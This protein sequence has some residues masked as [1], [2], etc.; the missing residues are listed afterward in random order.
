MTLARYEFTVTDERG[1]IVTDAQVEVR[2]EIAGA[3]LATLYADRDGLTPLG[4]PFNVDPDTAVAAFHVVGGAYRVRPF[5][6]G[7]ERIERYVG[8]GTAAETDANL[9]PTFIATAWVFDDATADADPGS[10]LFRL[11]NATPASATAVY[12]DNENA[13]GNSVT[14]W[15]DALDDG[16]D[17]STRGQLTICDPDQPTEVFR[18]YTVTG[19]VTDGT[20]YRKLS[21]THVSGAGSFTAGTPYSFSFAPLGANVVLTTRTLTAGAGLAGGGDLSANRTFDVG[22]GTGI[23]VN[24][25]DVAVSTDGISNTLLDNMLAW[26]LKARNAGTTGD[27]SDVAV[28]DLTEEADPEPGD[29]LVGFLASG[30]LRKFDVSNVGGGSS[31]SSVALQVFTANDT[32]TPTSGMAFCLVLSTGGG[33]GGGGADV[34]TNATQTGVGSGGG[35]GG[36]AIELFSAATIGANQSVAIGA[37][38]TA[39]SATNGTS[40][41]N[42]GNTTFGSLHTATGGTGGVG[43]GVSSL[44]DV[45][46]LGSAGGVPTG[47][48]LNVTGGSGGS[49]LGFVNTPVGCAM[50]GHGGSSMWGSGGRGGARRGTIATSSAG[51]AGAAYGS[52]GGG[53][54]TSENTGAA[55]GT[56]AAGVVIVLEFIG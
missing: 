43:S 45:I 6:V 35:A 54:V 48:L 17:A 13:G 4:N 1:N 15:L 55:G 37:A 18:I 39:G 28:G 21:V 47:G 22:A 14:A 30:E 11:N 46:Q 49:A 33:G 25:N 19:T 12:I 26:T 38:G 51:I 9:L 7:F 23:T 20:G 10:G 41:G 40:G 56:G 50:G 24:A 16:G 52:G 2:K 32:Y 5:K 3:P 53:G 42:G 27:P 8:I 29:M 34:N 36:T 31:I 44:A